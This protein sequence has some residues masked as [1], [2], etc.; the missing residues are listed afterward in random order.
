MAQYSDTNL[1]VNYL[2]QDMTDEQLRQIFDSEVPGVKS[3]KICRNNATGYSYGYGFCEYDTQELANQAIAAVNRRQVG[4]KTLKVA[5]AR[6]RSD[7]TRNCKLRLSNLPSW[8]TQEALQSVLDQYGSVINCKALLD[9]NGACRGVGFCLYETR[10]SAEQAMN[11]M[12][13]KPWPNSDSLP[14][15]V[16]YADQ[17]EKK[18]RAPQ[19]GHYQHQHQPQHQPPPPPQMHQQ[20]MNFYHHPAASYHRQPQPYGH[21][22]QYVQQQPPMPPQQQP[23]H[24]NQHFHGG[25]QHPGHQGAWGYSQPRYS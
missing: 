5:F 14:I 6:L 16:R 23:H 4:N 7:Q 22:P 15:Q 9:P 20:S 1:I 24:H 25:F 19:A 11:S 18:V 2:P 13:G 10:S 3:V 8:L 17:N 12:N 21:H